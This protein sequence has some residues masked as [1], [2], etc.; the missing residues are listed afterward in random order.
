MFI[1]GYTALSAATMVLGYLENLKVQ[2]HPG[3]DVTVQP[4]PTR[5]VYAERNG[6]GCWSISGGAL[7]LAGL[8]WGMDTPEGLKCQDPMGNVHAVSSTEGW[9]PY[10]L[11]FKFEPK[12]PIASFIEK[13]LADAYPGC[14]K[15]L[16]DVLNLFDL[17]KG[18]P[19]EEAIATIRSKIEAS[20]L[21][22][23]FEVPA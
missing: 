14:D 21:E 1:N 16:Q 3:D 5:E 17:E 6:Q 23:L 22:S 8:A 4:S 20:I 19:I 15:R 2:S 9:T 7:A 11:R 12:T 13:H 10:N 18:A